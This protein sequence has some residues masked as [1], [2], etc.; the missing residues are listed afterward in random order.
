MKREVW[1]NKY[2]FNTHLTSV[3]DWVETNPVTIED[4]E[5]LKK[6]AHKWAWTRGWEVRYSRH[7]AN[8]DMSMWHATITL[9]GKNK[10]RDYG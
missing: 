4:A 10:I 9:I 6:A 5:K 1:N 2:H 3:G 7:P 8:D